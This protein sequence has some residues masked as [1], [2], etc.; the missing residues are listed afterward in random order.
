LFN[1]VVIK[2]DGDAHGY[3][4][5]QQ[6]CSNEYAFDSAFGTDSTQYEIFEKTT[7]P[8]IP[9]LLSGF[10]VTVFAYGATGS[11][12]FGNSIFVTSSL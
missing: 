11:G 8:Y 7:K 6:A 10:N 1:L 3:L 4:R 2:K 9:N 12:I 5:S